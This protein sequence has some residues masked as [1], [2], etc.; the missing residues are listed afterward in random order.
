MADTP[1]TRTQEQESEHINLVRQD[2]VAALRNARENHDD[3]DVQNAMRQA[4]Q[5]LCYRVIHPEN[6]SLPI[7]NGA[8]TYFGEQFQLGEFEDQPF[9]PPTLIHNFTPGRNNRHHDTEVCT[10]RHY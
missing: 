6:G 8:V 5:A 2:I 7:E 10:Q 1:D 4:E 3:P 9:L